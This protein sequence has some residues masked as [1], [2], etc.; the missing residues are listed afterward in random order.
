MLKQFANLIRYFVGE[1]DQM[2]RPFRIKS[3]SLKKSTPHVYEGSGRSTDNITG[4]W[5]VSQKTEEHQFGITLTNWVFA[6]A[7]RNE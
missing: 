4:L 7:F 2:S 5:Q 6:D 3:V 1:V